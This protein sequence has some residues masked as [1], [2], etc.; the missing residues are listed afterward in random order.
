MKVKSGRIAVGFDASMFHKFID[1]AT[2]VGYCRAMWNPAPCVEIDAAQRRDL[3]RMARSRDLSRRVTTRARI[4]LA[5]AEGASN[6]E[7][8]RRLRVSRPT[9]LQWRARFTAGGIDALLHEAPRPGRPRRIDGGLVE[10]IVRTTQE[11]VPHP[12]GRWSVRAMAAAYGVSPSTVQRIW[13]A[14]NLV[15]QF[16]APL[17]PALNQDL[18]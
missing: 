5:A 9:V 18:S 8:E 6:R 4:V 15:P 10:A 16:V 13:K 1:N 17:G 14:R 2:P 12:A 3:R 7:V 11:T